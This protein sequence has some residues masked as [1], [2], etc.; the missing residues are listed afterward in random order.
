MPCAPASCAWPSFP[1]PRLPHATV[2][3]DTDV[4]GSSA[5]ALP[6][7]KVHILSQTL[8][9]RTKLHQARVPESSQFTKH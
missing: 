2:P 9:I 1:E 7:C 3:P 5:K 6:A 8:N 4:H